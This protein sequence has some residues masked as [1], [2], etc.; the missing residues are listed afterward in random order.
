VKVGYVQTSPLFGEKELNFKQVL[1]LTNN[2]TADLLVLPELFATGYTFVSNEEVASLSEEGEMETARFLKQLSDQTG[3]VIVAG[4]IEREKD[5]LFNSSMMVKNDRVIGIYRKIHLFNEEKRWFVPGDKPFEVYT[6]DGVRIGM[7]ICFDWIYPEVCRTLAIKG[8]QVIAHPSNLVLP[9][10]QQ[11]MQT[12]CLE[13]RIFAVTS[14][15]IGREQRGINDFTFTGSSQVTSTNGTILS[16]APIDAPH[17]EIVEIDP[18]EADNKRIN[19][20]ND[21]LND[22]R[23]EFYK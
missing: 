15:R 10:C 19:S 17:L 13:N 6:V 14:N 4:F 12:R 3:A 16:S 22:R 21:L 2:I 23:M 5:H 7:M 18:S 11:A 20:Y 1:D 8:A 9:W